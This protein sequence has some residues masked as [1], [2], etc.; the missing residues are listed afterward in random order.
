MSDVEFEIK[1]LNAVAPYLDA[2]DRAEW[3]NHTLFVA[4]RMSA[5]SKIART[6]TD[7]T[8]APIEITP[9]GL[10]YAIDFV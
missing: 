8:K 2:G 4:A 1:V 7:L 3:F 10:E 9:M 5:I 6:L